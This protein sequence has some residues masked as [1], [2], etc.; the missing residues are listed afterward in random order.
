VAEIKQ[1]GTLRVLVAEGRPQMFSAAPSRDPGLERELLEGFAR[2]LKV[3]V[4]P[5]PVAS[6]EALIPALLAGEG[7]L[8]AGGLTATPARALQLQFTVEVFPTRT[9]VLTRKPRR[10]V[11]TLEELRQERVG[12]VKG[13]S[14][15]EAALR[16]GL[17]RKSVD[18]TLVGGKAF[19]NALAEGRVTA[20]LADF[21]HALLL[22]QADRDVQF[23]MW[24]SPRQSLAFGARKDCPQLVSSLNQYIR[25]LHTSRTWIGMIV[26][27]FGPSAADAIQRVREE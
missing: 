27:Y 6:W 9:V 20:L 13:T 26:K 3:R 16:L 23:G 8:I 18:D 17:T 24:A 21:E 5:V 1:R 4:E 12:T 10:V 19:D 15:A 7:D 11:R 14:M 25:V 2:S 22:Q